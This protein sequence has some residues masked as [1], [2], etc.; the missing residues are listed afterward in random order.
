MSSGSSDPSDPRRTQIPEADMSSPESDPRDPERTRIAEDDLSSGPSVTVSFANSPS[1]TRV[2]RAKP[3]YE[4]RSLASS[5]D[6]TSF[7]PNFM[8]SCILVIQPYKFPEL[9]R[10][11]PESSEKSNDSLGLVSFSDS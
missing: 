8:S 3:R 2:V 7:F 9:E 6:P 10:R 5:Y 11:V 1:H 4:S